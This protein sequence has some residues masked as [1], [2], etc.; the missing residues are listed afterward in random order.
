MCATRC[1]VGEKQAKTRNAL[2]DNQ[3]VTRAKVEIS[4]CYFCTENGAKVAFFSLP[5]AQPCVLQVKKQMKVTE[6]EHIAQAMRPKL[7]AHCQR[8]LTTGILAEEADDIVQ[9]TLIRL[10][11]MGDKLCQYQNIEALGKT[12]ARNL[13]I[14]HLRRNHLPAESLSNTRHYS[15]TCIAPEQADQTIIGEDTQRRINRAMEK[16]PTTQRRMLLLRSEGDEPGRDCRHLRSQQ[17]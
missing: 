8:Y 7:A 13:C 3:L 5:L 12:I 15:K 17:G 1:K 2:I 11:R 14:D 16:L 6:F 9:E 10:W 4:K